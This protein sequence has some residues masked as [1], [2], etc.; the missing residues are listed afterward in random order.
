MMKSLFYFKDIY[1]LQ[2]NRENNLQK[3]ESKSVLKYTM[4]SLERLG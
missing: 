3:E 2:F 4:E 1:K